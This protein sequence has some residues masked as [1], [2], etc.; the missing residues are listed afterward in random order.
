[1]S[2]ELGASLPNIVLREA[3]VITHDAHAVPAAGAH[4]GGDVV[5]ANEEVLRRAHA[6]G[7]PR[8]FALAWP[9][10]P[11]LYDGEF[12]DV[13]DATPAEG[14]VEDFTS[15]DGAEDMPA[16][17]REAL[18][19]GAQVF[20]TPPGAVD[21]PPAAELVALTPADDGAVTRPRERAPLRGDHPEQE[22]LVYAV[23]LPAL[24]TLAPP[25][26][27]LSEV[28]FLGVRH[29]RAAKEAVDPPERRKLAPDGGVPQCELV[30]LDEFHQHAIV[31]WE[32]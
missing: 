30:G 19:P 31:E 10:A 13:A 28:K 14:P 17:L 8:D 32:C 24:R 4:D 29:V 11:G 26:A 3:E 18:Q 21:E 9:R 5:A 25:H 1:M 16:A 23:R 27:P 2:I 12:H 7:V 22:V 6:Q 20:C 15:A